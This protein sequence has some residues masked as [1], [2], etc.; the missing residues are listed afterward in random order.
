[1]LKKITIMN[2]NFLV[3]FFNF[4][5]MV[6]SFI[7]KILYVLGIISITFAGIGVIF[8]Q[9]FMLGLLI[10][11]GGNLA[12]RLFCEAAILLF[13]IHHELIRISHK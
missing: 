2:N 6:S 4:R 10:I 3:D 5:K 1:M 11:V 8:G 12:W 9:N 7:V 13:S